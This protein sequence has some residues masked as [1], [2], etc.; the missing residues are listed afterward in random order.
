M[1]ISGV[2]LR[3]GETVHGHVETTGDVARV[4]VRVGLWGMPLEQRAAGYFQGSGKIPFIAALFRG[5]W[6]MRIVAQSADGRETERDL[7]ITLR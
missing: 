7:P 6:M 1:Q 2:D 5:R 4:I 3:V